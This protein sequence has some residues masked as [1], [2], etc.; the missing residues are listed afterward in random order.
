MKYKILADYAERL[1]KP[2]N[3]L[4][5]Q[6]YTILK[7][8]Q[9]DHCGTHI[10][11]IMQKDNTPEKRTIR[12]LLNQAYKDGVWSTWVDKEGK[13]VI[14]HSINQW[15]TKDGEGI[16]A[17]YEDGDERVH[18]LSGYGNTWALTADELY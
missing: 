11:V 9:Q 17:T 15:F 13:N 12:E 10:C 18:L 4:A 1:E 7:V 8:L 6:G 2:V 3:D 5:A 16:V 14:L